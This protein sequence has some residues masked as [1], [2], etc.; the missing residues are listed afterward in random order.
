MSPREST[1]KELI[2]YIRLQVG[3]DMHQYI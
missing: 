2:S 3:P 1:V